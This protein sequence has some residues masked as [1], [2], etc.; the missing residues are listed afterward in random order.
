MLEV[1]DAV[2][3]VWGP[4]PG[5]HAPR[6]SR[7]YPL[8]G[9]FGPG[10][11]V[12]LCRR[13]ARPAG[14]RVPLRARVARRGPHRTRVEGGVRRH[15]SSPTRSSPR[16]PPSRC[17][18]DGEADAVAF[19]K[20]FIANPDLPHRFAIDAPLNE[21]NPATFYAS[22]PAGYT[23]YPFLDRGPSAERK[24]IDVTFA[25]DK[26]S[27]TRRQATANPW[28]IIDYSAARDSRSPS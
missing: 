27:L 6:S 4:G 24:R 19:G 21:P 5:R 14:P 3:S 8:D 28:E 23:D 13:R 20:L 22:G 9:R 1:A 16:R 15:L 25:P 11:D 10:R 7:R 18:R 26:M 2:V 17:S 12:R